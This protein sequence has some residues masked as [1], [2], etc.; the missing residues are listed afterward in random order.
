M[1]DFQ[2]KTRATLCHLPNSKKKARKDAD[3]S[4]KD[5]D[6]AEKTVKWAEFGCVTWK[7]NIVI[8]GG[9]ETKKVGK[10]ILR[11]TFF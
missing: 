11:L 9:K 3:E 8:S 7:G 2:H 4:K 6:S 10:K 5:S 1:L